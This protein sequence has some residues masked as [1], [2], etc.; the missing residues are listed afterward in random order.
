[1]AVWIEPMARLVNE[2]SKM[3]GIGSRSAARL[4]YWLLDRSEEDVEA[5]ASAIMDAKEQIH[6]CPICQSLTDTLPCSLCS[7]PKRDASVLCV[8]AE[9]R[10]VAAMERTREFKG[11]YHVLHGTISPGDNRGPEDLKIRELLAR[12]ED[13]RVQEVVIATNP[14]VEG[15]ATAMY[16]ARLIKPLGVRVSRIAHG[17]PVGSDLEYAD[18]VTLGRALTGRREM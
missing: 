8:V 18:E 13:G 12:L 10:D 9:P 6:L 5:L 15:E 17:V 2:L 11:L 14:D 4:A 3:P 1:M 7:D 16:L